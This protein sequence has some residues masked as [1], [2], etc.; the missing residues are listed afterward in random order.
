[1]TA[2]VL[3]SQWAIFQCACGQRRPAHLKWLNLKLEILASR[4]R[5]KVLAT[6]SSRL[7]LAQMRL[8]CKL[9]SKHKSDKSFGLVC[10]EHLNVATWAPKT[11]S[12]T[13]PI[14]IINIDKSRLIELMIVHVP[15]RRCYNVKPI[16]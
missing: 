12:P 10:G 15:S 8:N 6:C 4:M 2:L 7:P 5:C 1:M 13:N 14:M 3:P 11:V 9:L 16:D